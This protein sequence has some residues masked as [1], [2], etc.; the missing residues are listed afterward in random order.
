MDDLHQELGRRERI[1]VAGR[2]KNYFLLL[3]GK[4]LGLKT[5]AKSI[6][7]RQSEKSSHE[8]AGR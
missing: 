1:L 3:L 8:L 6:T 5:S 2:A 4:P 7:L